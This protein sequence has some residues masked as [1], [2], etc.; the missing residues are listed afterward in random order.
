VVNSSS[1][2]KNWLLH[3]FPEIFR[4]EFFKFF[5]FGNKYTAVSI[6]DANK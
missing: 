2:Y 6:L 4:R 5:P 3:I 1:I